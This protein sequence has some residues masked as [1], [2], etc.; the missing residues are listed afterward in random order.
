MTIPISKDGSVW[1]GKYEDA[2]QYA[3]VPSIANGK[4]LTPD[5]KKPN[6]KDKKAMEKL[7]DAATE[8]YAKTK[9]HLGIFATGDAADAYAGA[10]HAYMNDGT[11]K[12]V[13]TPSY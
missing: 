2:P 1:K 6:E 8:H 4:F 12:K 5:G 10:T 11:N 3:L 9:E 13:Y 7:E